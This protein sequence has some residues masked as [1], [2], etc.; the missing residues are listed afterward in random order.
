M[1]GYRGL[2]WEVTLPTLHLFVI[3]CRRFLVIRTRSIGPPCL[4]RLRG[5]RAKLRKLRADNPQSSFAVRPGKIVASV[6]TARLTDSEVTISMTT[7]VKLAIAGSIIASVTGYMAYLGTAESWKFYLTVD[8]CLADSALLAN[9]RMRV[10][11]R[12]AV[13][14][15]EIASGRRQA[16]FK[17]QGAE[18]PLSVICAG[19]LPD[20]LAEDMDVVVEGRLEKSGLLRGEKVLTRCAS[21]YESETNAATA[22]ARDTSV[23]ERR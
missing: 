19:P 21:K 16:K 6:G 18:S 20:N 23:E 12:V 9:Q 1:E 3:R 22:R 14:S 17:L 15:L 7:T 4:R 13:G 5:R 2:V 8:E 11:G 10:N